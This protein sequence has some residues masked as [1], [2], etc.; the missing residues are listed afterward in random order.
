MNNNALMLILLSGLISCSQQTKDAQLMDCQDLIRGCD[1]G[2]GQLTFS[3]LPKPLA[4]FIITLK[5]Q[6]IDTQLDVVKAQ[7]NMQGMQMGFNNYR[8]MH[9]KKDTWQANVILPV[10]S[11]R[12]ADW[13]M[14]LDIKASG[15]TK[16]LNILFRNNGYS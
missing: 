5:T 11:Q 2:V 15:K 13:L 10:C 4:P 12:R 1:I 14:T 7:F 9:L 8:F 16:K 3:Q 6:S